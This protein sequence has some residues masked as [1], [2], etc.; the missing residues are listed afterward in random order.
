MRPI[1]PPTSQSPVLI[2]RSTLRAAAL[3]TLGLVAL[4]HAATV[5]PLLRFEFSGQLDGAVY[6]EPG[7][8]PATAEVAF[9]AAGSGPIVE[10]GFISA[11]GEDTASPDEGLKATL[12][13]G[14]D[15]AT[16]SFVAEALVRPISTTQGSGNDAGSQGSVITIDGG[17]DLGF[18]GNTVRTGYYDGSST[19]YSVTTPNDLSL[20]AFTHIAA[21][22]ST[23][24]GIELF[25]NGVSQGKAGPGSAA[26]FDPIQVVG[27]LN[28]DCCGLNRGFHGDVDAVALSSFTG[29]FDPA[30]DFVLPVPRGLAIRSHPRST[31]VL[32]GL[33][34]TFRVVAAG[35]APAYQWLK[36]GNEIPGA[37]GAEYVTP[38]T[39][40]ADNDSRYSVR[41]TSG[42]ENMTST[43]AILT[44][45]P[46]SANAYATAVLLDSPAIYY[47]LDETAGPVAQNLGTLGPAANGLYVESGVTLGETPA[48]AALGTAMRLDGVSGYLGMPAVSGVAFTQVTVEVWLNRAA[49]IAGLVAL[50]AGD[51]FEAGDLH[52][53][54]AGTDTG[55]AIEWAV[56]GNSAHPRFAP[57]WE[58]NRWYHLAVTYD[59]QG[60]NPNVNVYLDGALI[61]QG[62]TTG[63][64]PVG[65]GG[66]RLG[67]WL[68][69]FASPPEEQR[70]FPG[71]LDEFAFY[72]TVLSAD[73]ILAHFNAVETRVGLAT[74]PKD[75]LVIEG[76]VATFSVV[77]TGPNPAY[78]WLKNGQPVSGATS[79]VYT[80]P[81]TTLADSGTRYSVRVSNAANSVTSSE[82]T[83]EVIARPAGGYAAT[84][85][86]DQPLV[87]YRFEETAG[88]TAANVGSLGAA[89]DATYAETGIALGQPGATA[90]LGKAVD[91]DGL[92]GFVQVPDLGVGPQPAAS[93]EFWLRR[94]SNPA[95]ITAVYANDGF[96]TY[97]L[98]LNLVSGGRFE[99]AVSGNT[100]FPQFAASGGL[101]E[102]HHVVLA[103]EVIDLT[104]SQ[105]RYYL[106]GALQATAAST[107]TPLGF[108][109]GRIGAWF[110][111][112][113]DPAETQRFLDGQLDEF[114]LYATALGP[115]QV[116]RHYAAA[117]AVAERPTLTIGRQGSQLVLQWSGTGF[118]LQANADVAQTGG[119]ADVPGA[120]TSP[121][122][123]NPTGA[124]RFY[125]LVHP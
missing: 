47:R 68:N 72:P 7:G 5:Q 24:G 82:A 98:H 58:L 23:T 85:L 60:G 75:A 88:P 117:N 81:P 33:P 40:A 42:G 64:S 45:V 14:L 118:I 43:E 32:E 51:G 76:S 22:Y 17:F 34:A 57:G 92:A 71:A 46:R 8:L 104:V 66:G 67:M 97:D 105:I 11:N 73:R 69:T 93:V 84:V 96:E 120:T 111:T 125:R 102:W 89:A 26:A 116:L 3:A 52:F 25:V 119:W 44:V 100:G 106:D 112:L 36:N 4:A 108:T 86:E 21:V 109:E 48:F 30:S 122:T 70:A 31:V 54:L 50:L 87:F 9:D 16:T 90:E 74:Q 63:S 1:R 113:A 107:E 77:A 49:D 41:V 13:A 103:Y 53:N 55:S 6:S 65:L 29:P 80:T 10:G 20:D 59:A 27:L 79:A 78:Q 39:V 56:A 38:P 18:A 123:V 61:G 62:A 94:R 91:L 101:D 12:D 15:F 19:Y 115:N 121:V 2:P 95:S 83:L 114:A 99:F 110:N 35:Q 37:T 28:I 124:S